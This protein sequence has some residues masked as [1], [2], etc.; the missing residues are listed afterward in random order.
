MGHTEKVKFCESKKIG[1]GLPFSIVS[2]SRLMRSSE[3]FKPSLR[4]FH[5]IFWLKKGSGKYYIDF[6]GHEIK[7][8]T[9]LLTSKDSLHYFEPF[10][11]DCE[12]QSIT[13]QPNFIY[14]NDTDLRHLFTFNPLC[15][16]IGKHTLFPNDKDTQLLEN[17]SGQMFDIYNNWEG[18]E[19]EDAF[20]HALCMFLLKCE[21]IK[22]AAPADHKMN[23]V[24]NSEMLLEFNELL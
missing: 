15:H 10:S 2:H 23:E 11:E 8:N 4:D 5:V 24:H 17:L 3:L 14:R 9:I 19:R 12:L 20:Y 1:E 16:F 13:F 6:E 21:R 7:P 18:K 22:T